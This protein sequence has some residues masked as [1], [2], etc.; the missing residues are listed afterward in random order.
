M[1]HQN[2]KDRPESNVQNTTKAGRKLINDY[3][4]TVEFN[5]KEQKKI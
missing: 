3:Q 1:N 4:D 5:L 2:Q